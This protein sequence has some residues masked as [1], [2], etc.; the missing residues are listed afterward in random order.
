MTALSVYVFQYILDDPNADQEFRDMAI[1]KMAKGNSPE[2]LNREIASE[3]LTQSQAVFAILGPVYIASGNSLPKV[4]GRE[5]REA[6]SNEQQTNWDVFFSQFE[7][8]NP[9]WQTLINATLEKLTMASS[10]ITV[11]RICRIFLEK[12]PDPLIG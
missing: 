7:S 6:L 11:G 5:W 8:I 12:L 10:R 4:T 9:L 3:I 1:I 2:K